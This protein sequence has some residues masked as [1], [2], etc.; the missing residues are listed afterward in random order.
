MAVERSLFVPFFLGMIYQPAQAEQLNF[1]NHR[2]KAENISAIVNGKK[3]A[4]WVNRFI[5]LL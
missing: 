4:K 5:A 1:A 2:W 3:S